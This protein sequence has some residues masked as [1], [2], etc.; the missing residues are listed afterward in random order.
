MTKGMIVFPECM[1]HEF[2][3]VELQIDFRIRFRFWF[4]VKV[5]I[6]N[7]SESQPTVSV[8]EKHTCEKI[9]AHVHICKTHC[10]PTV[11]KSKSHCK[12]SKWLTPKILMVLASKQLCTHSYMKRVC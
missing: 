8:L 5:R 1:E 10:T 4:G 11:G 3:I 6:E 12:Q 7:L 9:T 2:T